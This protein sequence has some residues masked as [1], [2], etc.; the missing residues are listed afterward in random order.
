[1]IQDIWFVDITY[2]NTLVKFL[3][4]FRKFSLIFPK[5]FTVILQ[6]TFYPVEDKYKLLNKELSF[7]ESLFGKFKIY[8]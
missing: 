7:K 5:S 3:L 6:V 4:V 8:I 2:N 1:M